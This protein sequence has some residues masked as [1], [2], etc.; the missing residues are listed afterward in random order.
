MP[1]DIT[2]IPS[3]FPINALLVKRM[4][5][6]TIPDDDVPQV[7][8]G[9]ELTLDSQD[10][11][12]MEQSDAV[13]R[14]MKASPLLTWTNTFAAIAA[15]VNYEYFRQKA[16]DLDDE[17]AAI[18]FAQQVAVG[19]LAEMLDTGMVTYGPAVSR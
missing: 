16:M 17:R 5:W 10:V 9:L 14:L 13:Q 2:G 11:A 18:T 12:D 4:L 7:M 1:L 19:V 3:G 6:N 8:K 15:N